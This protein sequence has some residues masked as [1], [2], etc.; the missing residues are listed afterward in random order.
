MFHVRV[1][2]LRAEEG[3]LVFEVDLN[4]QKCA[5]WT[6]TEFPKR[7]DLWGLSIHITAEE[8]D[9]IMAAIVAYGS[10]HLATKAAIFAL[11]HAQAITEPSNGTCFR[12]AGR[13]D[14]AS[15]EKEITCPGCGA[16]YGKLPVS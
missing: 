15:T 8:R 6:Y 3:K 14:A 7:G 16:L 9:R 11:A 4:G 5:P 12:C 1:D 13:L 10:E 2:S